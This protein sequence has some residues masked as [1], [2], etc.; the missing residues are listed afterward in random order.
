MNDKYR[1][2]EKGDHVAILYMDFNGEEHLVAQFNPRWKDMAKRCVFVANTM[3]ATCYKFKA[4]EN[5]TDDQ[6][7]MIHTYLEKENTRA[8]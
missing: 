1:I 2:V 8:A 7:K 5:L 6:R 3:I 4:K